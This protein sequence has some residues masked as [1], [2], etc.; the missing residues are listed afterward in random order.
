MTPI[1]LAEPRVTLQVR[2]SPS[3]SWWTRGLPTLI[4]HLFQD[5]LLLPRSRSWVLTG[6][7]LAQGELLCL[8]AVWTAFPFPIHSLSYP[9]ALFRF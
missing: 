7:H 4:Y 1:T 5:L 6:P 9:P 2:V 3:L 8:T